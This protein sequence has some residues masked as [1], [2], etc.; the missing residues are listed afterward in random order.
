LFPIFTSERVKLAFVAQH[1]HEEISVR[2]AFMIFPDFINMSTRYNVGQILKVKLVLFN[3][4]LCIGF[5]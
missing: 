1:T 4:N 5:F 2:F 3:T